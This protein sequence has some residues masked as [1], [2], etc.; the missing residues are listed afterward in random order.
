MLATNWQARGRA[1]MLALFVNWIWNVHASSLQWK[2]A[3]RAA[4]SRGA[5]REAEQI[6]ILW[7]GQFVA[8]VDNSVRDKTRPRP[9][10]A[11]QRQVKQSEPIGPIVML[12]LTRSLALATTTA[13]MQ[14][15]RRLEDFLSFKLKD[16]S[17][18]RLQPLL[19]LFQLVD[20]APADRINSSLYARPY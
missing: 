17:F 7:R 14:E 5:W 20:A 19:L 2:R 15:R 9:R 16:C 3:P 12:C 13:R 1:A 11:P 4:L 18:L 8:N 6:S 10:R